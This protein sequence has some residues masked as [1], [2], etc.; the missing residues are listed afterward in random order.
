M[1]S[2]DL[3]HSFFVFYFFLSGMQMEYLEVMQPPSYPR[4][5]MQENGNHTLRMWPGRWKGRQRDPSW[6]FRVLL[7]SPE[8]SMD[9]LCSCFYKLQLIVFLMDMN[10]CSYLPQVT[11]NPQLSIS[12]HVSVTPARYWSEGSMPHSSLS[13]AQNGCLTKCCLSGELNSWISRSTQM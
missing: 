4:D 10:I 6:L 2:F 12:I 3:Y 11:V 13:V 7:F 5:S 9:R 1:S 8:W